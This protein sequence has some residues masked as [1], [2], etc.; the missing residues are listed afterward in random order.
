MRWRFAVKFLATFAAVIPLWWALSLGELYR[1]AVHLIVGWTSPLLTGWWLDAGAVSSGGHALFRRG[2]DEVPLLLNLPAIAMSLMPLTSLL[3]ATPGQSL[4]LLAVRLPLAV[5]LCLAIH[6]AVVLA[7]P[8]IVHEPNPV[9]DTVGVFSGLLA[10][11]VAPLG[12]WFGLTYPTMRGLWGIEAP[13][14]A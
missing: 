14:A 5:G 6:A 4:R 11:V 3:V 9:K 10:F 8:W 2:A 13:G 12:V 1:D 7:F